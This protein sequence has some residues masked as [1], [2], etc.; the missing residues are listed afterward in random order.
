MKSIPSSVRVTAN[1]HFL[2]NM[3]N[4]P[5]HQ[6]KWFRDWCSCNVI[7]QLNAA[8][9]CMHELRDTPKLAS[10]TLIEKKAILDAN[11]MGKMYFY[12]L[13]MT[14]GIAGIQ[15]FHILAK[16][17][18]HRQVIFMTFKLLFITM[19]GH[20]WYNFIVLNTFW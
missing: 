10:S 3:W 17:W 1:K 19:F 16:W 6:T 8:Y 12:L 13:P 20:T 14:D 4:Q 2:Q 15:F 11:R 18:T 9:F 7:E 5:L